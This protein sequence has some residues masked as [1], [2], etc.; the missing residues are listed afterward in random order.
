MNNLQSFIGCINFSLYRGEL[1]CGLIEN[2]D[3]YELW[4][5]QKQLKIRKM[6]QAWSDIY[7]EEYMHQFPPEPFHKT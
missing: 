5:Q 7:K 2:M 4:Q 6:N 3:F 1:F